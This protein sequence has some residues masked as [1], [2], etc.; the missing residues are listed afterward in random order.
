[1]ALAFIAARSR[2]RYRSAREELGP[3]AGQV[4]DRPVLDV[5]AVAESDDVDD[6][7]ADFAAGGGNSE[8]LALWVPRWDLRVTARSSSAT[9]S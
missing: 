6:A 9:W 2:A 3:Q 1:M 7:E 5:A 4:G 8:E